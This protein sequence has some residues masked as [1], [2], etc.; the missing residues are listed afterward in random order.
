MYV[1]RSCAFDFTDWIV[2][3]DSF[4]D[5]HVGGDSGVGGWEGSL[6]S[7][8]SLGRGVEFNTYI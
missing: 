4:L 2:L 3:G 8:G 5:G 7:S 6:Y 1:N